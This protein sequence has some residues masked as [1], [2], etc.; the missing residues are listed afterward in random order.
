MISDLKQAFDELTESLDQLTTH[1]LEERPSHFYPLSTLE[2]HQTDDS[3]LWLA[4]LLT[5]LSYRDGQDGRQTRTRHGLILASPATQVLLYRTNTAKEAFATIARAIKKQS[6]TLWKEYCAQLKPKS[7]YR[8]Q[9]ATSGLSRIHLRQCTRRIALLDDAPL[10]CGF[11]WYNNGRSITRLTVKEAEAM[12]LD[13][14][15]EKTHIQAQLQT[16]Y[17]L[18]SHTPLARMQ[19]LAPNVRANLVFEGHR[20]AM[21]CPLPL[22]IPSDNPQGVLPSIKDVPLEPPQERQGRSRKAR[23]DDQLS[24]TPLLPSLRVF[25]YRNT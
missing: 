21:N 20:K 10:K 19:T 6:D 1:L 24:D 8:S 5:D 12:L 4:D 9:M 7:H 13:L 14:G 11:T 15:E 23:D 25:T 16:L 3:L 22:F 2:R 17:Q 18:P